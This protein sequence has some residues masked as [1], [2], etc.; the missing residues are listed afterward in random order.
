MQLSQAEI[1]TGPVKAPPLLRVSGLSKRFGATQ[2]LNNVSIQFQ[3]GEIHCVLGEN[4]AG[5]STVG[6]IISG[7]YV[8]DEG[9]VWYD[10]G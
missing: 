7:L 4:G 9:S 6:K 2:A 5:K 1:H 10:G 3:G 8:A